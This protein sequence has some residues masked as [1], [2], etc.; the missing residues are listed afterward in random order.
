M[1]RRKII[2]VLAGTIAAVG[3][4]ACWPRQ[5]DLRRFDPAEMARLETAT[6]RDY[7]EKRY[8]TLFYHLTESSRMQFGFSQLGSVR[9][10]LSAAQA[11]KTFQPTQSR[12]EANAALP[13]LL[14]Y[15]GRLR[16]ASPVAFDPQ[17]AARLELDWWQAR[18]E[19]V[20]P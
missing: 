20:S 5:A 2:L 8:V 3:I 12:Q 14:D 7:Y 17:Q 19:A 18:R 16:T 1:L 6:W 13:Y 15:F 10:A 4:Y 11:A 9:I